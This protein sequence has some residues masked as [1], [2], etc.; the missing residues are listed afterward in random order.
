M[1]TSTN[2]AAG[3][4]VLA[5]P[6][7]G[8]TVISS[9]GQLK[10]LRYFDGKF[11]RASDL[12]LEQ[13][14]ARRLI[15]Q[16]NQ[17]GGWGVVHGLGVSAGPSAAK[18]SV[19]HGVA[20]DREG[21]VILLESPIEVDVAELIASSQGPAPG[22]T[23]SA[24]GGGAWGPCAAPPATPSSAATSDVDLYLVTIGWTQGA[25]GEETVYGQI[26]SDPCANGTERPYFIEGAILRAVPL[27]LA[28]AITSTQVAFDRTHL[29]SR[30]AAAYFRREAAEVA[31]LI[32]GTGLGAATWCQGAE[33][34]PG[35]SDV[36][37]AVLGRRGGATELLDIWTAR[38]ERIEAPPR[39]YW[40]FRMRMR[41]W[42]VFL[43]H[44]L[45]FQC[46]L[47]DVL[48]ATPATPPPV[49]PCAGERELVKKAFGA[50]GGVVDLLRERGVEVDAAQLEA[51]KRALDE[52]EAAKDKA[53]AGERLGVLL[54][55]G[56][57]ELPS[58]G[59]L[60]VVPG[61]DVERQVRQLLGEGLDLRFCVTTEDYVAHALETAQHMDRISLVQGLDDPEDRPRVDVLVPGAK[62]TTGE[63]VD[64]RL[65][66]QVA[67]ATS[68]PF[69][70]VPVRLGL[71]D[72]PPTHDTGDEVEG[73]AFLARLGG[74][75]RAERFA[76]GGGA[77]Y[78]AS[79]GGLSREELT[80]MLGDGG[81]TGPDPASERAALEEAYVRRLLAARTGEEPFGVMCA[82]IALSSERDPFLLADG[83]TTPVEA[84]FLTKVGARSR[85]LRTEFH[86]RGVLKRQR[87]VGEGEL[88]AEVDMEV[89]LS[90]LPGITPSS[91]RSTAS[92]RLLRRAEGFLARMT[93]GESTEPTGPM[94]PTRQPVAYELRLRRGTDGETRA[95]LDLIV[96]PSNLEQRRVPVTRVQLTP[97]QDV[98]DP[99]N[100]DHLLSL[101]TVKI[102]GASL[103]DPRFAEDAERLLFGQPPGAA[104]R[105]VLE[106]TRD[107]VLFH[108]RRERDCG[109]EREPSRPPAEPAPAGRT[110]RL[111]HWDR[112]RQRRPELALE[113][114]FAP[115]G[116][117]LRT[118]PREIRAAWSALPT[119]PGYYITTAIVATIGT[120]NDARELEMLRRCLDALAPA[121]VPAPEELGFQFDRMEEPPR[122]TPPGGADGVMVLETVDL[123]RVDVH[124]LDVEQD[125]SIHRMREQFERAGGAMTLDAALSVLSGQQSR[126]PEA[127]SGE[128]GLARYASGAEA[129]LEGDVAKLA[130]K[131]VDVELWAA[132]VF[133][134][135]DERR[136]I[137]DRR[138]RVLLDRLSPPTPY[139]NTRPVTVVRLDRLPSPDADAR[140]VFVRVL[141]PGPV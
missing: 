87:L 76:S 35:R 134:T 24:P 36:P 128:I 53:S 47:R 58:A 99:T 101:N 136:E 104:G 75:G 90:R 125:G 98:F 62:V 46:H 121:S 84:R 21:R 14:H 61:Q 44:V 108:R 38:R 113:I 10:R 123:D 25:C 80:G 63:A 9:S 23:T 48:Q 89:T 111:Y 1:T 18:L 49:D 30:I 3:T 40:A 93:M 117:E 43:A 138:A 85:A 83:E 132:F 69:L 94:A 79:A 50:F 126:N 78:T 39:R 42:D 120:Q 82:W 103:G 119:A 6:S 133:V 28:P 102:L 67:L 8:I 57:V 127:H 71:N 66:F 12:E 54:R 118:S 5:G 27:A 55:R 106:P 37:I 130:E 41:P 60:P 115:G 116:V 59:Y 19:A 124:R 137:S 88:E 74:A 92:V 31:S 2:G 13:A 141:F 129:P 97:E 109:E 68:S 70:V 112:A 91:T 72:G 4:L 140:F 7:N 52:L 86:V 51:L 122:L 17:A 96:S 81:D 34:P 20:I 22:G 16:S 77:F 33:L 105:R 95:T 26:C 32:S 11:L 100:D 73:A 29:R 15:Q 135:D 114:A 110:Y 139:N 107:W 56:I 45:Q 64:P 131:L 65:G